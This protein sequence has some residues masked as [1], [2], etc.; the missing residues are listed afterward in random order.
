MIHE[1]EYNFLVIDVFYFTDYENSVS[2]LLT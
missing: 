2:I 1:N